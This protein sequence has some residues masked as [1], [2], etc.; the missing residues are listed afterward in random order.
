MGRGGASA[1]AAGARAIAED[2]WQRRVAGVDMRKARWR[3]GALVC[4][5]ACVR[6]T[7]CARVRALP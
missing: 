7:L 3:A 1:G 5:C 6:A 4:S 2:D